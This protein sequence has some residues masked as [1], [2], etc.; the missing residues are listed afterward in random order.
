MS[1]TSP[2]KEPEVEPEV[3]SGEDQEQ[4]DKEQQ[5]TQAQGQGEFEVKEQDRWLPIA[6]DA[7]VVFTRV[8]HTSLILARYSSPSCVTTLALVHALPLHLNT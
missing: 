7:L 5:D 8:G 1:S 3:Q 6:N 2:S 4:M